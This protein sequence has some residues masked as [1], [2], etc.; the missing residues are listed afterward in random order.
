MSK[1]SF[2]KKLL[3][4]A[5]VLT[6]LCTAMSFHSS[7]AQAADATLTLTATVT[8]TTCTLS[9]NSAAS[10][11]NGGTAT[12]PL[13]TSIPTTAG[14]AAVALG[15]ALTGPTSF[16]VGFNAASGSTTA[17]AY[18]GKL[19]VIFGVPLAAT[20][21][22]VNIGANRTAL[23]AASA[24]TGVGIELSANNGGNLIK[25]WD[26]NSAV[27]FGNGTNLTSSQTGLA[28]VSAGT[29]LG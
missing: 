9:F 28:S 21:T 17:C 6:T 29:L 12:I 10:V 14:A 4:N 11:A 7:Y 3:K 1:P 5:A 8:S 23:V 15:T 24:S 25:I 19:N 20:A 27:T 26:Y 16:T 2:I 18:A 13:A 22:A